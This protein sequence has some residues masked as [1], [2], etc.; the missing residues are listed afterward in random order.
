MDAAHSGIIKVMISIY[1]LESGATYVVN[2]A[3]TDY[4][5]NAFS[6]G[7]KLTYVERHFLPYEGGH[8]LVFRECRLYLQEEVNKNIIDAFAEYLSRAEDS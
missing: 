8:T 7:E 5:G 1:T 3:F 2:R 4:Y 6:V